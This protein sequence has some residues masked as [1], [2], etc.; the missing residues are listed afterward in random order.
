MSK[1][2]NALFLNVSERS[3]FC[4]G[5][6]L[7]LLL[8][9]FIIFFVLVFDCFFNNKNNRYVPLVIKAKRNAVGLFQGS[10]A[11]DGTM[12]V[13]YFHIFILNT[14]V[15]SALLKLRLCKN[16]H[17]KTFLNTE[18]CVRFSSNQSVVAL[19]ATIFN[20]WLRNLC[21]R[22][23]TF[24]IFVTEFAIALQAFKISVAKF[25]FAL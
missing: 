13:L 16:L 17:S 12:L 18:I 6:Y 21:L 20:F 14:I 19:K 9:I 2:V 5:V 4:F 1:K 24:R 10:L 7:F 3:F 23:K 15:C 11:E 22:F 8:F 25:A